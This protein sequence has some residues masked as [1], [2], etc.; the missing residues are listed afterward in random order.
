MKVSLCIT[1][2]GRL[3]DLRRTFARN[4]N[5][6][7]GPDVEFVLLN[8]NS[9]DG[10]DDWVRDKQH[11]HVE[12]GKLVYLHE[13]TRKLYDSS[14][15]KN[16]VHRAATGNILCNLDA[17]NYTGPDFGKWLLKNLGTHAIGSF[18]DHSGY[19][20]HWREANGL[21]GRLALSRTDFL[22][23]GGYD[24][25]LRGYGHD[26]TDLFRR[27]RDSGLQTPVF[28]ARFRIPA[29]DHTDDD[30]VVNFQE[31]LATSAKS[32]RALSDRNLAAGKLVANQGHVWGAGV[33]RKNW[34]NTVNFT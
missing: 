28:P 22:A 16:M 4:L 29:I 33:V 12:S 5:D 32:N 23:L 15:A 17:D 8:Y 10:L 26:D 30:R 13:T 1:C 19:Y 20:M 24:E 27:A 31:P 9:Q 6:N 7:P 11:D 3:R 2:M 18:L 25:L 34:T 21:S 14:H